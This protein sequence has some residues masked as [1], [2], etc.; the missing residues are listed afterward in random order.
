MKDQDT[1]FKELLQ[2]LV[3]S[4]E[5]AQVDFERKDDGEE[6]QRALNAAEEALEGYTPTGG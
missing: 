1:D 4:L 2:R 5:S 3:G 6:Y